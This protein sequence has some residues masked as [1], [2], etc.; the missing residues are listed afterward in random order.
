MT[1]LLKQAMDALEKLP[2]A[3]QNAMAQQIL[4]ELQ[5]EAKWNDTFNDPRSEVALERLIARAKEQVKRGD[6]ADL[7]EIL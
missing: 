2:E 6:V 3:E 1:D 4:D 7:D 5:D